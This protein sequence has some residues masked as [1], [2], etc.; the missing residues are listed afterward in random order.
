MKFDKDSKFRKTYGWQEGGGGGGVV[1]MGGINMIAAIFCIHNT[2]SR[3]LLQ[4]R[5]VS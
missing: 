2:L 5:I 1:V 3:P 4:N